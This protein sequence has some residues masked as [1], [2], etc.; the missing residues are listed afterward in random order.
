[1]FKELD[2][3][4]KSIK[5]LSWVVAKAETKDEAPVVKSTTTPRHS[6]KRH[7]PSLAG[8]AQKTQLKSAKTYIDAPQQPKPVVHESTM[9]KNWLLQ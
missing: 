7:T 6:L 4:R 9:S 5:E 1:M 3:T 2:S 8:S